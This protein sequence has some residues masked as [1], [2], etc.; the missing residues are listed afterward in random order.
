MKLPNISWLY[1]NKNNGKW[2]LF[3]PNNK[4]ISTAHMYFGCNDQIVPVQI[5]PLNKNIEKRANQIH[6][7]LSNDKKIRIGPLIGILSVAKENRLLGNRANFIDIIRT[8]KKLGAL[9]YVFTPDDLDWERMQIHGR[10]YDTDRKQWERHIVPFPDVIYNRVP[11]RDYE[12]ELEVSTTIQ[13]L[14]QIPKLH[15]FNPQFFDKWELFQI[16][17]STD[18]Q[19]YL[20]ETKLLTDPQVL[21]QL[22]NK[23]KMLYLKPTTGKAG[24][25]IYRISQNAGVFTLSSSTAHKKVNDQ[26]RKEDQLWR[27]LQPRIEKVPYIAQQA[28]SLLTHQGAPFDVRVLVQKNVMGEWDLSGIGFRVA[29]KDGITTHVPQG[30][31]IIYKDLAL[32]PHFGVTESERLLGLI[33]K[34]AIMIAQTLDHRYQSLGEMSMDL[35]LTKNKE[36]WFFEANAKPMKFDEPEIRK[37]SLQRIIEYSKYLSGF[38]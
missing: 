31:K 13:R 38:V 26:I 35:G 20:P 6:L 9:V 34:T 23:H 37:I 10:F 21:F 14:Q 18:L 27:W 33:K 12:A 30:G 19:T 25:G 28:I 36:I 4:G 1:I 22:L 17:Q 5:E 16:L 11:N 24:N 29:G 15:L 8:G 3:I 32:H 7:D 2:R